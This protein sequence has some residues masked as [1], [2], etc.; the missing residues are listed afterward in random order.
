MATVTPF[1][2]RLL[3][4]EQIRDGV[5]FK[6][7]PAEL[8]DAVTGKNIALPTGKFSSLKILAVGVNGNQ[9]LQAFTVTYADGTSSSFSRNLSDWA[10]PR[11]FEGESAAVSMPYRLT[12]D[13][14]KDSRTFYGYAYSFDLDPTKVV[15]SFSVPSNRDVVVFAATLVS[16]KE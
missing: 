3:G 13:G 14:P 16:A 1:S 6:L 2:E 8:P 4:S 5:I 15:R 10:S 9:E 12:A 7:G 11:N